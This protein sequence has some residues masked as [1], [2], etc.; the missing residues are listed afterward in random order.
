[1]E[2][3]VRS[4]ALN[5]YVKYFDGQWQGMIS[6]SDGACYFGASTHSPLHGSSFFKFEPTTRK[7]TVLAEDMTGVC[8]EDLA[9]TPPQGKIHS[10]IVEFDGW[11]YLTT[12]LSNYWDEAMDRYTGA[13][14]IGY[15]L[16]TGK[17]RDFGIVR[18]RYTIYSAINVDR[19]HRK[20][21]VFAVPF[22]RADV[23]KDGSHLY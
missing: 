10:P 13:H 12:H 14:V 18:E 21:Y 6:A 7:L 17:F 11:L 2:C 8:G 23:E 1:M 5:R 15:Q 20:L 4:I 3:R 16:S 19:K 9:K 22:A